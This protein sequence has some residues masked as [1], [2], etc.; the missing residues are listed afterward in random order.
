MAKK[1]ENKAETSSPQKAKGKRN[2]KNTV[3]QRGKVKILE[4][5]EFFSGITKASEGRPIGD[6]EHPTIEFYGEDGVLYIL[7]SHTVLKN[8][9]DHLSDQYKGDYFFMVVLYEGKVVPTEKDKRPYNS[10]ST[11]HDEATQ[12]D[13]DLVQEIETSFN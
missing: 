7:P 13:L 2:L 4:D 10:Y 11:Q 3:T 6:A 8:Q 9:V 1:S 12:E 5:G